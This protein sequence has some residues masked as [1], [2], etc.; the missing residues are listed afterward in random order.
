MTTLW[1]EAAEEASVAYTSRKYGVST[2]GGSASEGAS[3]V[4]CWVMPLTENTPAARLQE[5]DIEIGVGEDGYAELHI[6]PVDS[7][8]M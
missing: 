8:S 6:R 7:A 4:R 1:E 2:S 3:D 5:S